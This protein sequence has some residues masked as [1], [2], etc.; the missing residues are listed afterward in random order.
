MCHLMWFLW[1]NEQA[2]MWYAIASGENI[3]EK[4]F[5]DKRLKIWLEIFNFKVATAVSR[6]LE[7]VS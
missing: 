4:S 5:L 7:F 6:H 2:M 1:L 3:Q